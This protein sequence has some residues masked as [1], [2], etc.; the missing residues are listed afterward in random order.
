MVIIIFFFL[1]RNLGSD[2]GELFKL[3]VAGYGRPG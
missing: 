2:F 3:Q 1:M